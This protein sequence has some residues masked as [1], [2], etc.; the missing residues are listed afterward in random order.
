M[1]TSAKVQ[2]KRAWTQVTHTCSAQAINV[3]LP[4]SLC[5]LNPVFVL[6]L[7]YSAKSSASMADPSSNSR[8]KRSKNRTPRS[9]KSSSTT[10]STTLHRKSSVDSVYQVMYGLDGGMG[11]MYTPGGGMVQDRATSF[12]TMQR[13]QS[14]ASDQSSYGYGGGDLNGSTLQLRRLSAIHT[15]DNDSSRIVA[16]N[17]ASISTNVNKS[18]PKKQSSSNRGQKVVRVIALLLPEWPLSSSFGF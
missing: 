3:H 12:N 16:K 2:Q 4:L 13:R 18:R 14:E 10:S 17:I 11:T 8:I 1:Q 9:S 5:P 7:L 6:F 15:E